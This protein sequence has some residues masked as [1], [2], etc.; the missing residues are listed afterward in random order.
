MTIS[1]KK[2]FKIQ[3]IFLFNCPLGVTTITQI[4]TNS[5]TIF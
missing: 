3:Q 2:L 4:N 5:M 1:A